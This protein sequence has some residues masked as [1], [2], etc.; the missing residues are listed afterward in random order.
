VTKNEYT[1]RNSQY[2]IV[3]NLSKFTLYSRYF[4]N[5]DRQM[6]TLQHVRQAIPSIDNPAARKYFLASVCNG[7]GNRQREKRVDS[8]QRQHEFDFDT[9]TFMYKKLSYRR[10]TARCVV[11]VEIL[12]IATKQ[13]RNYLYDKS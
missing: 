13:C 7:L 9:A 2:V 3:K 11:S 6:A 1:A 4:K 12:P 8:Q 10:R 5:A